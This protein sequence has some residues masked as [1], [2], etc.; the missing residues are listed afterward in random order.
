MRA[1]FERERR[2]LHAQELHALVRPAIGIATVYRAL[3][4][5]TEEGWLQL[6]P[7]PGPAVYYERSNLAHHHHFRCEICERVF[8][9]LGCA[10]GLEALAPAGFTVRGQEILLVG[11]CPACQVS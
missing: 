2:P 3:Q 4:L 5:L 1:V 6:V 8:D 10:S 11:Q 7:M 9:I